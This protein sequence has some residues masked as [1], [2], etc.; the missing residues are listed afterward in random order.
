MKTILGIIFY[1]L[2]VVIALFVTLLLVIQSLTTVGLMRSNGREPGLLVAV[3]FFLFGVILAIFLFRLGRNIVANKDQLSLGA[4]INL[5]MIAT[6]IDVV[7]FL[8]TAI[9][10]LTHGHG[11]W[12]GSFALLSVITFAALCWLFVRVWAWS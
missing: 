10:F 8:K 7:I 11:L 5:L 6:V 4:K 2:T 3:F 9:P 1:V 12:S